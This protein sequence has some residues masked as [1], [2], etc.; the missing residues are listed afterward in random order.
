MAQ[1]AG[2]KGAP[3]VPALPTNPPEMH[4]AKGT[5]DED[6]LADWGK[7]MRRGLQQ[8]RRE[9][10][11]RRHRGRRRLLDQLQR[12][13]RRS[14]ARRTSTRTSTAFQGVPGSEVDHVN[15]WG[16]DGFAIVEHTM[17]RHAEGPARSAPAVEQGGEG[18]ALDRHHAADGGRQA[19]ARLGLREPRRGAGSRRARLKAPGR[20]ARA[21]RRRS[22][23][24][25]RLTDDKRDRSRSPAR[26]LAR[27]SVDVHH[28]MDVVEVVLSWDATVLGWST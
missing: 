28:R 14:R 5:P 1:M 4:V 23:P 26:E 19:A 13:R 12:A 11:R 7:A 17:T 22:R 15:A 24:S 6:K 8:G 2:K 27:S 9:G 20:Q 18:L 25:R 16:I 21:P 3:P 10:R